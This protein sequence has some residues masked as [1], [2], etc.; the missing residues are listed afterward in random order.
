MDALNQF[1]SLLVPTC[2]ASSAAT[3]DKIKE[4]ENNDSV[5]HCSGLVVHEDAL[6]LD[7]ATRKEKSK[8]MH[9]IFL[10]SCLSN[11]NSVKT[12]LL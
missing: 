2:V 7:D 8:T 9:E 5:T 1:L 12:K 4:F 6:A 3:F 11:A 10:A